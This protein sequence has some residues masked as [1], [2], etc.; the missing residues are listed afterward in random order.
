[1]SKFVSVVVPTYNRPDLLARC[2]ECLTPE[3]QEFSAGAF[4]VIVTDDGR[5][6]S[7]RT[8][9][10]SRFPWVKYIAGPGRGPA[11]NRNNGARAASGE[12][13]A[14]VDDDCLPQP[15]WLAS[16]QR[17]AREQGV[18]VVEGKTVIPDRVDNPFLQGVENLTGGVFWSCNLAVRKETFLE[19]GGFDE[20]FLE[21]GGEDMEFAWRIQQRK[22]N[23]KFCPEALVFHPVRP[24]SLKTLIWRMRLSRWILLYYHRTGQA[25][26]LSESSFKAAWSVASR[27]FSDFPRQ[28]GHFYLKHL[29]STW[30]TG[31][32]TSLFNH[33]WGLLTF[34]LLV[35]YMMMWE[36][37]FRKQLI[38]RQKERAGEAARAGKNSAGGA[39]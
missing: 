8:M 22:V 13:L 39:E 18:E 32:R 37:R 14:F 24:A 5:E 12:W 35:P 36:L 11:A 19:L 16:I 9:I 6:E 15:G 29:P 20:D 34:P 10:A 26:P 21:A 23:A 33:V 17:V 3:A 25:V 4:E 2:L 31:W 28:V 30:R 27:L 1:M 7:T 38:E